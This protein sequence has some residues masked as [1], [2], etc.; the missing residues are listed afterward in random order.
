MKVSVIRKSV[1]HSRGDFGFTMVEVAGAIVILGFIISSVFVIINNTMTSVANSDLKMQ[2]FEVARENMEKLL[3]RKVIE[4]ETQFGT[5]DHY[6]HVEWQTTVETFFEPVTSRIWVQAISTAEYIDTDSEPQKIELTH[7]L[8]NLTEKQIQEL[9]QR[10]QQQLSELAELL[11]DTLEQAAEYIDVEIETIK[12]WEE[13]GMPKTPIGQYVI[14]LL[15]LYDEKEGNPS[16]ED[17]M[18]LVE[19]NPSLKQFFSPSETGPSPNDNTQPED[20]EM[21][22]DMDWPKDINRFLGL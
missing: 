10:E 16:A 4:E 9:K 19:E 3:V 12:Q 15:E 7:W 22:E 5:S 6:P 20:F 2:A 21:P 13:N 1:K 17:K 14:P 8:T 18:R 11:I